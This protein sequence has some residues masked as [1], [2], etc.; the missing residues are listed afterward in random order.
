MYKILTT[1]TEID[2]LVE[3]YFWIIDFPRALKYFGDH[4]RHGCGSGPLE[5][6]LSSYHMPEE[7]GCIGDQKVCFIGEPPVYDED[8]MAVIEY[9]EFYNYLEICSERYLQ[10]HPKEK[11]KIFNLLDGVR[12]RLNLMKRTDDNLDYTKESG[13]AASVD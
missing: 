3:S 11:E 2:Q 7:E 8:V 9:D 10:E 13:R 4:E 6:Q 5:V 1:K 12:N